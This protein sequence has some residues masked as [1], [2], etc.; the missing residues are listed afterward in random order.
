MATC[1]KS[2]WHG[3]DRIIRGDRGP[4]GRFL[5]VLS[6]QR[7]LASPVYVGADKDRNLS[8]ERNSTM[9]TQQMRTLLDLDQKIDSDLE[10]MRATEMDAYR[11]LMIQ[12]VED[13]SRPGCGQA[14]AQAPTPGSPRLGGEVGLGGPAFSPAGTF[15]VRPALWGRA[16]CPPGLVERMSAGTGPRSRR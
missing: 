3:H 12:Y 8:P 9:T 1:R 13:A 16:W 14:G 11:K 10:S 6:A 5:A 2:L 4:L 7:G 15:V